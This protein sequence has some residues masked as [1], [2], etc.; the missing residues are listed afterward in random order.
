V[1]AL[2]RFLAEG[3]GPVERSEAIQEQTLEP[4]TLRVLAYLEEHQ[5]I[6]RSE[7]A[8]LCALPAPRASR[9][10][11]QLVADGKIVRRGAGRGTWYALKS[12]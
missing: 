9:L 7:V 2:G 3:A 4:A 6:T 12:G 10:L 5:R 1:L 11:R 8:T